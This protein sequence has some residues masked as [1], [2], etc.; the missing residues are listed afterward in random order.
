MGLS[1]F[2]EE[3]YE[4][5]SVTAIIMPEGISYKD[6]AG[7]LKTKFG[8]VVGGGLQKLKGKILRIGHLGS[9]HKADIYA[10]MCAV[11]AALFELGYK[12]ELGSAARAV[13]KVFLNDK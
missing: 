7:I 2:T 1:I 8:V 4:S 5:N 3:G 13:S 11:E 10:I 6:L 12:V 9:I